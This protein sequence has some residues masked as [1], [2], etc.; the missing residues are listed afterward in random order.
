MRELP[1]DI[2]YREPITAP[3]EPLMGP[4]PLSKD[5]TITIVRMAMD[6]PVYVWSKADGPVIA[7]AQVSALPSVAIALLRAVKA[8]TMGIPPIA[9][10]A[11]APVQWRVGGAAAVRRAYVKN[12]GMEQR[13]GRKAA[14]TGIRQRVTAAVR[15]APWKR[16]IPVIAHHPMSALPPAATD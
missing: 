10:A 8:A 15:P 7:Q 2:T 6:A 3:E 16:A 12:V 13:K 9:T 4:K 1:M 5:A 14:T 11:A